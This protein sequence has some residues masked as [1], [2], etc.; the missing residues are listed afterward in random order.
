MGVFGIF[1]GIMA[2]HLESLGLAPPG[3]ELVFG[4]FSASY[5]AAAPAVG[6]LADRCSRRAQLASERRV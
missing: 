4:V 2:R 1:N 5:S 3:E 6:M